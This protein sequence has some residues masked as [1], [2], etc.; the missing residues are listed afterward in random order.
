MIGILAKG[1]T[2]HESGRH[3]QQQTGQDSEDRLAR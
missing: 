1:K 3:Q 2:S